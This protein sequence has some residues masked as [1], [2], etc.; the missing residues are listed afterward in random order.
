MP[1]YHPAPKILS[2]RRRLEKIAF[3]KMPGK[4]TKIP[5]GISLRGAAL[6]SYNLIMVETF[7]CPHCQ[8]VYKLVRVK[9]PPEPGDHPVSCLHCGQVLAPRDNEF[10]LKYFLVERPRSIP[11]REPR[12]AQAGRD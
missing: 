5:D 11:G 12:S 4:R 9:T 8:A 3:K 2:P 1:R 7:P 6:V 10:L